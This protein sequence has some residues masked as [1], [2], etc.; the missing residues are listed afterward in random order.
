MKRLLAG[1]VGLMLAGTVLAGGLRAVRERVEGSMVVTGTID[2]TPEGTVLGFALDHPEKLP[3]VVV[4][5][6]GKTLPTWTFQPVLQDGKPVA[7]KAR[8][9]LRIL[10]KPIG[11]GNF[12]VAV[13][14]AYF[15]DHRAGMK[16]VGPQEKP[17]YPREAMQDRASGTAYVV[18]RVDRSGR[19][20][21]AFARQVDLRVLADDRE[22]GRLRGL[23]AQASVKALR[24]WAFEPAATSDREPYRIAL[25]PVSY[26]I[27]ER[28][29][30]VGHD[31]YGQWQGYVP[32]P[33]EPAPWFD[34]DKMLSGATDALSGD[35]VFGPPSL[36]LL[37]PLDQ[38]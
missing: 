26:A 20:A 35:G 8:M 12:Q 33:V 36:S 28:G 30:L 23:F 34:K 18:L 9:N 15:G 6:I 7:A 32:G 16:T 22:L 10:A 25:V 2:I 24:Q 19:V 4:D 3:P 5:V 21:D 31:A 14:S 13:R 11:G 1:I 17:H 38:G 37:T 29:H 27:G